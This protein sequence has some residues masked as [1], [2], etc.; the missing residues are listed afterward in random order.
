[1]AGLQ[2]LQMQMLQLLRREWFESAAETMMLSEMAA[3]N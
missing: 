3:E 1:L 2:M